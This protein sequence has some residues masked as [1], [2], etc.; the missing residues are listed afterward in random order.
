M[1][2]RGIDLNLLASLD[3]LIE[4]ANVTRAAARLGISQPALSAQ[5]ARLRDV[6]GDPLLVPSETGRGMLPT[7]RA[8]ELR[9]P[10]HAA[11]KDLEIVVRRPPRF[12]PMA[13][14]R[15]FAIAASDN[16]TIVLGLALIERLKGI[17][18]PGI[19]ISFQTARGDIIA[20]QLERG[21]ID[22]MIGS[23][24]MVQPAMKARKLIDERY[25]MVQ[26][27]GHPRGTGPLDLQVYCALD[28]VLVSTSGGSFRGFIDEQL[29]PLGYRRNVALSVHQFI[30]APMVVEHTDFVSTLPERFARRFADRV[31]IFELPFAAQGFSLHAGW[32]PRSHADPAHRW[33]REQLVAVSETT[34]A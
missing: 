27:K 9:D 25:V 13:D 33:L 24:L 3:V 7:T 15:R 5:L 10:L 31:D 14:E 26:R 20:A 34:S 16:A 23:Q 32:H 28:H 30:L 11:L 1:D 4:E 22:L 8:L 12:D 17:A 21:D 2:M 6:F 18:G 29:E 19:R